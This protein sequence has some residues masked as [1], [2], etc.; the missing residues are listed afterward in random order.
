MARLA[1]DYKLKFHYASGMQSREMME[2]IDQAIN[3]RGYNLLSVAT[4]DNRLQSNA[5]LLKQGISIISESELSI[6][7]LIGKGPNANIYEAIYKGAACAV[8][9]YKGSTFPAVCRE[10]HILMLLSS[11]PG[12]PHAFGVMRGCAPKLVLSSFNHTCERLNSVVFETREEFGRFAASF[13]D[14][15]LHLQKKQVL[16]N[17]INPS[18]ILVDKCSR[19]AVLCGFSNSC[20]GTDGYLING[21]RALERFGDLCC[22]PSEVKRAGISLSFESDVYSMGFVL[23]WHLRVADTAVGDLTRYVRGL[24]QDCVGRPHGRRPGPKRLEKALEH[25]RRS[26]MQ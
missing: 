11:H 1:D 13:M 20:Y 4:A 14:I 23:M 12:I 5:A 9:V 22:L 18:N 2:N 7:L 21:S 19:R 16:H 10:Y 24:T 6:G 15:V 17:N 25:I 26:I 3:F 8:K